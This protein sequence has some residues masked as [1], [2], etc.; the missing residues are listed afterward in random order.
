MF[1]LAASRGSRQGVYCGREGLY[2]GPATLIERRDGR[3]CLR[4]ED[5]ITTLLAAAYDPAPDCAGLFAKMRE[6]AVAL[7][8]EDLSRAMIAA[9][10]LGI[11]EISD[12]SIAWLTRADR[13]SKHAF[14]SLEPRDWHGR[15]SGDSS[16]RVVPARAGGSM[17]R[18]PTS[19]GR[20]WERF[21]NAEFRNRLATAEG[22]AGK[23]DF[24]YGE[25]RAS[26]GALSRYQM[27]PNA[28]RAVGLLD[29][30]G[31]WTGKYGIHSRT[32]FLADRDAQ[33]RAL[34]DF[35]T[36]TEHQLRANG[37]FEYL[38]SDIDGR[39]AH[40]TVT[41]A[42]LI[43]AGHRAGATNTFHYLR[44]VAGNGFSSRSLALD[45]DELATETRLRTFADTQYE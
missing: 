8:E 35:L 33:E 16:A 22:N 15:W 21:P 23:D 37:A 2:L 28:L 12:D 5:E 36:D 30:N 39:V 45:R 31:R 43:A 10:Q 18:K 32:Q 9:L 40:Y 41:R 27:L 13:L 1:K 44:R 34:S 17:P 38:G 29:A 20:A 4:A 25:V 19:G 7:E 6:V 11:G 3:F 24:G 14:N 26:N 42:G